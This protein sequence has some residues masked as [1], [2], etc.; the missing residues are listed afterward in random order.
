MATSNDKPKSGLLS[1]VARFVANP[2]TN[3]TDLEKKD[4]PES[5][6]PR[7]ADRAAMK[8]L[9]ELKRRN[10][11]VRQRE[12]NMLRKLRQKEME[13]RGYARNAENSP[14]VF[15]SSL[16]SRPDDKERT[17]RK[18]DEI[19]AQMSMQWWSTKHGN[20]SLLNSSSFGISQPPP[21]AKSNSSASGQPGA[22]APTRGPSEVSTTA[23]N[24]LEFS[25]SF[26]GK[27]SPQA[28]S[29][30][31]PR[32]PTVA[33]LDAS[34]PVATAA[35]AP[36]APPQA[37]ATQSASKNLRTPEPPSRPAPPAPAPAS[38]SVSSDFSSSKMFAL[39]VEEVAH[40]A[41]L[42]EAAIRFANGDDVGA[43]AALQEAMQPK[44]SGVINEEAWL[45][46][47]D[48]YRA[49]GNQLKFEDMSL[50]YAA[51]FNKSAPQWVSFPEKVRQARPNSAAAQNS[52][53]KAESR[54]AH[55]KSPPTLTVQSLA[56][57]KAALVKV[58]QPWHLD[59]TRLTQIDESSAP[60][61]LDLWRAWAVDPN[62][63][64]VFENSPV[65]SE[66]LMKATPTS[67]PTVQAH[68]W[69]VRLEFLRLSHRPDEF[70]MAALD[71]CVTYELSPPSWTPAKC[72]FRGID[73]NGISHHG[74]LTIVNAGSSILPFDSS[75]PGGQHPSIP[76]AG[77]AKQTS[78]ELT[79]Y[80][81]GDPLDVIERLNKALEG[82]DVMVISC[83]N[84]IRIDFSA[85]GT[86]LN[87]VIARHHEGRHVQFVQL[88]RLIQPFFHVIGISEHAS[89]AVRLH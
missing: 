44:Q 47:F 51:K 73:A 55:W 42:E 27:I 38:K 31:S 52:G 83:E 69:H 85:A 40:D 41:E 5:I 84:L 76:D 15:Q 77:G 50:A 22:G 89:T 21:L 60:V 81:T 66:V 20:S 87:W 48:L 68:W 9:L 65:L 78:I 70:E 7:E 14:S 18:I 2:T 88:H 25:N 35:A 29:A 4:E 64:L 11:F 19:E 72:K 56:A 37:A 80:I 3:W 26:I 32:P 53:V 74:G 43:E 23:P 71:F 82:A 6:D 1:K 16:P 45:T 46:L 8:A 75:L 13:T 17:L 30:P 28:A 12:F 67:D 39:E 34:K 24:L 57:M 49:T 36:V 62:L 10:D 33:R 79:G 58:P 54:T 61:L 63:Q 59:W 86:L